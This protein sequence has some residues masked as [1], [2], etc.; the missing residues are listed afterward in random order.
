VFWVYGIKSK[1][2]GRIYIG[3]TRNLERRLKQHNCGGV[4]STR[5]DYPWS[6]VA[7]KGYET[8]REAR[9]LEFQLKK[10][11][12]RRLKWISENA[13]GLRSGGV[14]ATL[15]STLYQQA[16]GCGHLLVEHTARRDG[17]N[18]ETD[19]WLDFAKDCGYLNGGSH[20]RLTEKCSSVGKMLGSMLKN[21]GPFLIR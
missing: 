6:L 5:N 10:S 17:E 11:R 20:R 12:G 16:D 18:S 9:W 8:R 15:R 2:S 7:F 4:L 1:I 21:P 13:I 14:Q 19:T 3:Q